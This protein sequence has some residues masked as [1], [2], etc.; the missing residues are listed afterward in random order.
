MIGDIL[1]KHLLKLV[2]VPIVISIV[3]FDKDLG[4]SDFAWLSALKNGE[5]GIVLSFCS[6]FDELSSVQ[7]DALKSVAL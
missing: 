4:R 3:E 2:K 7:S 5:E 6:A 1:S